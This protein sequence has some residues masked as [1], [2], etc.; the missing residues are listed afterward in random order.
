MKGFLRAVWSIAWKDLRVEWRGREQLSALAVFA[1]LELAIFAFA[2]DP[3]ERDLRPVFPGLYWVGFL[4]AA[5]L[6]LGRSFAGE[7]RDGVG[8]ALLLWP[9]DRSAIFYGKLLGTLAFMGGAL[10]VWTP[11]FFI[12]LGQAPPAEPW[13]FAASV[14]LATLGFAAA[15]LFLAALTAAARA[16]EVL[17]PIL[18][19]PLLSPVVIGAVRLGEATLAGP[20]GA[21]V[22][23]GQVP[24]WF[25]LL[26][27]YAILFLVLPL[28]LFETLL[29]W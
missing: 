20:G 10:A 16:S 23:W 21:G 8:E 13:L 14:A 18:L 22:L 27:V 9:V 19:A 25:Q 26:G 29:E 6:A 5:T 1:L 15:G 12:L 2:F 11:L 17:F 7:W 28:L 3:G 24:L 4:F